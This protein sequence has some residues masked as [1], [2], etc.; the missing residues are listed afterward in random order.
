M[1][2]DTP[3]DIYNKSAEV[4]RSSIPNFLDNRAH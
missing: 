4:D 2:V 3:G 1:I